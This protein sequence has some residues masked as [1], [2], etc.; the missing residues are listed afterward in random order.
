MSY[1]DT[2][3]ELHA[4]M[5][6]LTAIRNEKTDATERAEITRQIDRL[7]EKAYDCIPYGATSRNRTWDG[8]RA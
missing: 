5:A 4:K 3:D 1:F 8:K 6:V 7:R 2:Y